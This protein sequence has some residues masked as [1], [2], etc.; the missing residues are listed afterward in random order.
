MIVSEIG[1]LTVP[2]EEL[3]IQLDLTICGGGRELTQA[4]REKIM[5]VIVDL[6]R[7]AAEDGVFLDHVVPEDDEHY[8]A[9]IE[10]KLIQVY[11]LFRALKLKKSETTTKNEIHKINKLKIHYLLTQQIL[12]NINPRSNP[13]SLSDTRSNAC[14]KLGVGKKKIEEAVILVLLSLAALYLVIS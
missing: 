9:R 10:G 8:T 11:T 1:T 13:T 5:S 3:R 2:K 12:E 6:I 7:S 14:L 4:E